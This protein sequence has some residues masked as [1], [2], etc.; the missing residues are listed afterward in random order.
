MYDGFQSEIEQ[1]YDIL[2]KNI[3]QL[4]EQKAIECKVADLNRT[5]IIHIKDN[6]TREDVKTILI[7]RQKYFEFVEETN[8]EYF[9]RFFFSRLNKLLKE[10]FD[11]FDESIVRLKF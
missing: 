3:I 1:K 4:I 5:H 2:S 10:L 6:S 11:F 8:S 9:P 7:Q